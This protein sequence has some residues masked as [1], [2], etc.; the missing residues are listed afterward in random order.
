MKQ[1]KEIWNEALSLMFSFRFLGIL[2]LPHHLQRAV[3]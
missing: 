2:V 3:K 1:E